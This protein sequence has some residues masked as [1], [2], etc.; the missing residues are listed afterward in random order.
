MSVMPRAALTGQSPC[1]LVVDDDQRVLDLLEIA[2]EGH[3]FK[4]TK[5]ADGDDAIRHIATDHPVLIILDV[6]LPKKSGLEVCEI[7][8]RDPEVGSVPIIMV[9]AAAETD[10]R[11]RG[12]SSGADD[13]VTKPF[14]PKE[15]I[16]RVKR[17][18][19]RTSEASESV[20]RAQQLQN[21][22]QR[23]K[24]EVQR[25]HTEALHETRLREMVLGPGR[26]LHRSLD[27]DE[28]CNRLLVTVQM[29]LGL[30]TVALLVADA[31]QRRLVP[32]AVRGDGFERVASIEL[33]LDGYLAEIVSGLDR[34][35]MRAELESLRELRDDMPALIA[36]GFNLV[37]PL[38]G[39]EGLEALLLAEEPHD[40]HALT[41]TEIDEA[42]GL[43]QIA[44]IALRNAQR[45][46]AQTE[47]LIRRVALMDG[48]D[49]AGVPAAGVPTRAVQTDQP[50]R[51]APSETL[52]R[53]TGSTTESWRDAKDTAG[54]APQAVTG[55][56]E[57][58]CN[59]AREIVT[60]AAAATWLAA[61]PRETLMLAMEIG[62]AEWS[63]VMEIG[64]RRL[65]P[66]DPTGRIRD[67]LELERLATRLED[68]SDESPG[69]RR[70]AV[71]LF[72]ARCFVEARADGLGATAALSKAFDLAGAALEPA[73]A[74]ALHSAL[75]EPLNAD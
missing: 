66:G 20:R 12:L 64:F 18:L 2:F 51:E 17:L 40:G 31:E 10:A 1:I 58:W 38:R 19:A 28:I 46:R 65:E 35:V 13:Y 61:R 72:V 33:G 55:S 53:I 39:P 24:S 21:E 63:P 44:A 50:W 57:G 8:R 75:L 48:R 15:L 25:T 52:M 45:V 59:D 43:C 23:V 30:G 26:D 60:R 29:R 32:R 70:A 74:Q 4:V 69:M 7:L 56:E 68:A 62:L 41:R 14:S 5:A 37:V 49:I 73:T 67:L 42:F 54:P 16:A 6:R 34:I 22:L 11:L 36:N 3:G 47:T 27:V 9:S 71:F